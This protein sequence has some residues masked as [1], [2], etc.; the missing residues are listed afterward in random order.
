MTTQHGTVT[1]TRRET[2]SGVRIEMSDRFGYSNVVEVKG[3]KVEDI[4]LEAVAEV[5]RRFSQ[6]ATRRN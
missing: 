6:A 1:M 3:G 2:E 5:H 4:P